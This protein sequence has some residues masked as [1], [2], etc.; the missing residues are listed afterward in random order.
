MHVRQLLAITRQEYE[1]IDRYSVCAAAKKLGIIPKTEHQHSPWVSEMTKRV[2]DVDSDYCR[3]KKIRHI[4]PG[5]KRG[6]YPKVPTTAAVAES[7]D[8]EFQVIEYEANLYKVPLR[9]LH[10]PELPKNTKT[11]RDEF[12]SGRLT[13]YRN[14]FHR[15]FQNPLLNVQIQITKNRFDIPS[16]TN[17]TLGRN[18]NVLVVPPRWGE[19]A[20]LATDAW[21]PAKIIPGTETRITEDGITVNQILAWNKTM[22]RRPP[23]P[24]RRGR[25]HYGPDFIDRCGATIDSDT[26]PTDVPLKPMWLAYSNVVSSITTKENSSISSLRLKTKNRVLKSLWQD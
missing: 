22:M 24:S 26:L 12:C 4:I 20:I 8:E 21:L 3:R 6:I 9:H 10:R 16:F 2:M 13:D 5:L 7:L 14:E 15:Q 11:K 25:S 19:L 17:E 23:F 18:G 1:S